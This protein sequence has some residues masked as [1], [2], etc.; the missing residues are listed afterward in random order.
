MPNGRVSDLRYRLL[1]IH[2]ANPPLKR[3][4]G[5]RFRDDVMRHAQ[6]LPSAPVK[7]RTRGVWEIRG[8]NFRIMRGISNVV[9]DEP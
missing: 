8:T 1:A 4:V 7:V 5:A 3:A 6:Q 9:C 2:F